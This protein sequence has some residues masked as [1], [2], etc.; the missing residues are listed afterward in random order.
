MRIIISP[1][2]KMKVNTDVMEI[3]GLPVFMEQTEMILDWMKTELHENPPC[4]I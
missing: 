2:K 4:C 3:S 1:A